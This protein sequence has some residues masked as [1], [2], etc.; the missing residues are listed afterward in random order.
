MYASSSPLLDRLLAPSTRLMARL[1]F[2]QKAMVIG[3]AFVVTCAILAGI[4][5]VKIRADL[6]ETEQAMSAISPADALY[7]GM[8]GMQQ[9]RELA[10]MQSYKAVP[11]PGALEAAQAAADAGFERV[12]A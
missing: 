10:V 5:F 12:A 2:G 3:A 8:S 4:L 1:R 6:H 9:H 11:K 7:D